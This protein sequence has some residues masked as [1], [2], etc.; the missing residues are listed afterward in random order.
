L[1]KGLKIALGLLAILGGLA[2]LM[3]LTD[4][5]LSKREDDWRN[6]SSRWFQDDFPP[7]EKP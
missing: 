5:H 7:K 2:T 4:E 3:V 1:S 6:G